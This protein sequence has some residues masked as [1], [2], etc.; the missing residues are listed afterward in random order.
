MKSFTVS[1][2]ASHL[3][4]ACQMDRAPTATIPVRPRSQAG[5]RIDRSIRCAS[6]WMDDDA[7]S[8]S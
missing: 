7:R 3:P 5:W 2:R 6:R 1:C 8:L 4:A